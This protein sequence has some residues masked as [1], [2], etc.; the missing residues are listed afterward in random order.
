MINILIVDDSPTQISLLQNI[1]AQEQ[2][3]CVI[4]FARNGQEAVELNKRLKPDLITMD[5]QMPVMDG[6]QATRQI[7]LE[8]PT[9]IVVISTADSKL[10]DISFKSLEAGALC[11]IEK[12]VNALN[13]AFHFE[14]K[15]MIAL[16][17]AMAEIKVIKRRVSKPAIA[18]FTP[19]KS[20][21]NPK[22]STYEIIGIGASIGGPQALTSILS[23]LPANFSVPI[24]IVQHMTTGFIEGFSEWMN[25]QCS[26]QVKCARNYEPLQAGTVYFAPS[27]YHLQVKRIDH[28]LTACL[29]KSVP[30]SGF[31]PSITVLF[32]SIAQVC[33]KNAVGVLL[34]GMGS[35]GAQGMLDLKNAQAHTLIQDEPSCVVYGM[36]SVAEKMGAVDKIISLH[37][38]VNYLIKTID[39]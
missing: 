15:K 2:D 28:N 32:Q 14:Q 29:Q 21:A 7:M 26:I 16:I 33:G 27:N 17:R 20:L 18:P 8:Q 34:T 24:V 31:C 3:M 35:D 10:F 37:S 5:I 39:G 22:R 25:N 36:A 4:G 9:P 23:R 30:I 38:M 19:N 1:F 6:F 12:P 11:V 13:P